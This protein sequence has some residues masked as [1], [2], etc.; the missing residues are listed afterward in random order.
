MLHFLKWRYPMNEYNFSDN[1]IANIVQLVQ[2]A[3]VTG[4]DIS[5]H[6]RMIKVVPSEL[7]PGKLDLAPSYV[8]AHEEGI[9]KLL[10][11]AQ[12]LTSEMQE[13]QEK[14]PSAGFVS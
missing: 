7:V 1:V 12:E 4:T 6:F 5:D 9:S 3:M 11:K 13:K 8:K 14:A 10:E 2:L